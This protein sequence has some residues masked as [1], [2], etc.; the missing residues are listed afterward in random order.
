MAVEGLPNPKDK[1]LDLLR[2]SG[3][4][5]YG[6]VALKLVAGSIAL[7][8]FGFFLL[9]TIHV[10]RGTD[11]D[12]PSIQRQLLSLNT[13]WAEQFSESLQL[14]RAW[15]ENHGTYT[16]AKIFDDISAVLA[17]SAIAVASESDGDMS[18]LSA[19]YVALHTG[20]VRVL[21][22]ILASLRLWIV[23]ILF[24]VCIGINRFKPYTGD[25]VLGQ[26]GNGRLFYSGLRADLDRVTEDGAPD[27]QVRGLACPQVA[28]ATEAR[29]SEIWRILVEF[30]AANATNETLVAIILANAE[31]APYV[32]YP[33]ED[34]LLR[35]AFDGDTLRDNTK[36]LLS[37]ILSLHA[38]YAA[39]E[40][41]GGIAAPAAVDHAVSSFEYA[42]RVRHAMHRILTPEMR[43]LV[44]SI[45]A[46]EIAT[47]LL[48]LEAGKVLAHSFEGGRWIKRS[49][50]PQ[51]SARAVL[52]SVV[53]YPADY[54]FS[55]RQRIRRA[56]IYGS[57]SSSF[58]PVRMPVDLSEDI[59][60][61][62]QWSEI[63]LACP[64]E[65][66]AVS[67]E[68]ELVGLVRQAHRKWSREFSESSVVVSPEM[69]QSSYATPA[70]L[71]FL[72]LS[73]VLALLRKALDSNEIRRIEH[74]GAVVS[75]RQKLTQLAR[76]AG[77]DQAL[78]HPAFER[79]FPP[80]ANE[81]MATLA[82]IHALNLNDVKDWSALRIVLSSYGW[83]ARRVGDYTV[84]DSSLIF[85]VFQADT[86][87]DGVNSLG[88]LGKQGMVPLRGS[89]LQERWGRNWANRFLS[90]NG[91]TMAETPE[92]FEKLLKG[93]KETAPEDPVM[94]GSPLTA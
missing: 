16:E 1:D 12:L 3:R 67:D 36:H 20:A 10:Y 58:A 27:V 82:R 19:S 78:E 38:L 79:V 34:Q 76:D 43:Q 8:A 24:A 85:A 70:N 68:V 45:P 13:P 25:D 31:T 86:S 84:P 89:K 83:L 62:R 69:A 60:V 88:L 77:D 30:G 17:Q 35:K 75:S 5:S 22:L 91:A 93:I 15:L 26:M 46:P 51:L 29:A 2:S 49:N 72:P 55:A 42:D 23:S 81:E 6:R 33:E 50:F 54:D 52:H 64:H 41:R 47:T 53:A 66:E 18:F 94:T 32:T 57:R 4:T 71:L 9:Y 80:L 63:L 56:L 61:L 87:L 48:A 90:V 92:D 59:W 11:L 7:V 44:G 28:S 21:F 39:G 40:I 14:Q 74:L 73:R 65:L 37:S